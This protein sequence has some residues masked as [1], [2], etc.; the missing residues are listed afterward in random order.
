MQ[1]ALGGGAGLLGVNL[2][3]FGDA[4][5]QRVL[6]PLLDRPAPPFPLLLLRYRIVLVAILLRQGKQA[7]GRVGAAV[8]DNVLYGLAQVLID[9]VVDGELAALTMPIVRPA[10]TAW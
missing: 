9:L 7:L 3:E 1:R 4:V 2:D 5:D 10:F 6:E 8:Q